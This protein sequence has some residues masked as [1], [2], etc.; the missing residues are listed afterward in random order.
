MTLIVLIML[1]SVRVHTDVSL[2]FL[3]FFVFWLGGVAESVEPGSSAAET[4]KRIGKLTGAWVLGNVVWDHDTVR[5]RNHDV[6][7]ICSWGPR[8]VV[9]YVGHAAALLVA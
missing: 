8:R 3:P 6:V 9:T 1:V 5:A 7:I 2:M 4:C